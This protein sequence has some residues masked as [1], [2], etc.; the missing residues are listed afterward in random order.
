MEGAAAGRCDSSKVVK[1]SVKFIKGCLGFRGSLVGGN[2]VRSALVLRGGT[3][4][5]E[6][7]FARKVGGAVV[8]FPRCPCLVFAGKSF[9]VVGGMWEII[10]GKD[11]SRGDCQEL[12]IGHGKGCMGKLALHHFQ[13][14]DEFGNAVGVIVIVEHVR[15]EA[16]EFAWV[17]TPAVCVK[18]AEELLG[19]NIGVEGVRGIDPDTT[20][21]QR[22]RG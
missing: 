8:G 6:L 13:H 1:V 15:G 22:H 9:P 20:S 21:W 2:S 4:G 17:E 16:K 5:K 12:A 14:C 19:R 11:G 18:V 7:T 10:R 3:G